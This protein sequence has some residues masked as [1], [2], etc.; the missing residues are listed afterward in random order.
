MIYTLIPVYNELENLPEL[1]KTLF[2]A[3]ANKD[4]TFVFV[5][6]GSSDGTPDKIK[7]LWQG[8]NVHVLQNPGNQGPGYSFN[9]GFNFI[10]DELKAKPQDM[11]ITFEGDNTS[12][13]T[14]LPIMVDLYN[15]GFNLILASPYAQGGGFD[16][17]NFVRKLTS[18]TANLL[19]RL[20]FDVKVLTLSSF[21]RIYSVQL[22][23]DIR[24][25][26]GV[27]IK[28]KGFISKVEILVKA[29]RIKAKIIEVPMTL[30]SKKRKGKSKMKVM[31]TMMSYLRF[32][33]K[34]GL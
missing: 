3:L 32:F 4:V 21:Y 30:H 22:L 14:I 13:I 27:L 12:D 25:K 17:T 1:A 26:Y 28:E 10:L 20:W 15:H 16:E 5:D 6:D 31:K 19:L 24:N 2:G 8:K 11:V 23:T 7:E 9:S 18:F 29:I 34:P 33:L